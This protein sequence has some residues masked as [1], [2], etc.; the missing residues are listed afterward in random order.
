MLRKQKNVVLENLEDQFRDHNILYVVDYKGL[1]VEQVTTLRRKLREGNSKFIVAKNTLI[2]IARSQIKK[3]SIDEDILKGSTAI[4]MSKD[5][6]VTPA[7]IL[8]EFLKT[9]P[10]PEVKAII[11]DNTI[12]EAK[13]FQQFA[14]LPGIDELRAKVVGSLNSPIYGLV[15]VLSGLIRGVVSQLD[16]IAKAKQN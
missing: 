11:I 3:S 15:F 16:Q 8:K 12:Y 1:N 4:I 13:H 6:P 5:D 2:R 10:K 7:K 9:N 14:E